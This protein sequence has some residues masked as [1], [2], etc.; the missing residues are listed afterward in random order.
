[1]WSRCWSW[2]SYVGLLVCACGWLLGPVALTSLPRWKR[3]LEDLDEWFKHGWG[4]I[5][6]PRPHQPCRVLAVREH[7]DCSWS[8][9]K[10]DGDPDKRK[11][12]MLSNW[13]FF[14][15]RI[16]VD[17]CSARVSCLDGTE[18][19]LQSCF[20]HHEAFQLTNCSHVTG[21][22]DQD[23]CGAFAASLPGL[24]RGEGIVQ[25]NS[26][27]AD[28]RPALSLTASQQRQFV[29]LKIRITD[30]IDSLTRVGKVALALVVLSFVPLIYYHIF[31][32]PEC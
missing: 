32:S 20:A 19:V 16:C 26:E 30:Q 4:P 13:Q 6:T 24:I 23:H 8:G 22:A 25:D 5:F 14:P 15:S 10:W 18:V 7:R 1:M 28:G 3:A 27:L 2:G 31:T 17:V 9:S 11:K 21:D 29:L 12:K